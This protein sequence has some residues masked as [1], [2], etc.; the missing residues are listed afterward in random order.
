MSE[1]RNA[2]G[3][4]RFEGTVTVAEC[5]PLGMISLRARPDLAA[6]PVAVRA[7]VGLDLPGPR[8][9]ELQ[10][11]RAV[12]WMSPDEWLLMMPYTDAATC[13]ETLAKL[14]EGN[15]HL[16]TDVSDA[17]S[18]FQL[19]GPDVDAVLARLCPVDFARFP[20][21]ELRRTRLAQVAC[22]LWRSAPDEVTVVTF[23]S[24]ARY[25]FDV[26]ANAAR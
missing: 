22:A 26:L 7:A 6:L 11:G 25:A 5:E 2:L 23:R 16:T 10:E 14:L 9:I 13:R 21:R 3:N 1:L 24:V 12:G 4:A 18:V 20:Q 15:H 17:R 19:G 8:G